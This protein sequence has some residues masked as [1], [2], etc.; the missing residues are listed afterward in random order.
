MLKETRQVPVGIF[1]DLNRDLDRFASSGLKENADGIS[2]YLADYREEKVFAVS[3][4]AVD[5]AFVA[6]RV[7][8]RLLSPEQSIASSMFFSGKSG[9]V[10]QG[11]SLMCPKHRCFH[12]ISPGYNAIL[13]I[14]RSTEK[15]NL[16]RK[17]AD[18]MLASAPALLS[19]YDYAARF[20][21]NDLRKAFHARPAC[22]PNKIIML[23]DVS[24]YSGWVEKEG[25]ET[26]KNHLEEFNQTVISELCR[27]YNA[28]VIRA[29]EGDNCWIDFH[30]GEHSELGNILNG[31]CLPMARDIFDG[32]DNLRYKKGIE[33]YPLKLSLAFGEVTSSVL[34]SHVKYD[35]Y[36]FLR[37]RQLNNQSPRDTNCLV[38]DEEAKR[39]IDDLMLEKWRN[40]KPGLKIL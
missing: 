40:E 16:S 6:D 19:R 12:F 31:Q 5:R 3:S 8:R 17:A 7:D 32:Y 13:Q 34:G 22:K 30:C 25:Y 33:K 24:G 15:G 10:L 27:V 28:S 29:P 26:V 9:E 35:G 14:A 20:F 23:S 18:I 21:G 4:L 39:L 36:V 37:A 11:E 1:S 2:V 38:I